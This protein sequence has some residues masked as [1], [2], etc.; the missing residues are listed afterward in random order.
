MFLVWLKFLI[1][2]ALVIF[3]GAKLSR[4]G[5]MIAGKTRL[6]GLWVGLLLLAAVTS[7]PELVT[8]IGAAA[9]VGSPDLA[10]GTAFGSNLFNLA[11]IAILDIVYRQGPLLTR[12]GTGHRLSAGV[13]IVLIGFAAGSI[14]LGREWGGALGWVG[15]YSPV[16]V[17]LYLLGVR[18]IFRF[19]QKRGGYQEARALRYKSIS[20]RRAYA[21]FAVAALAIIGLGTW[22]AIIGDELAVRTGWGS[23]FVGSLFLAATTSLP[24]LVVAIVALRLGAVDMA[25]ANMLGSNMFNMGIVIA[26]CDLFYRQAS[27]FSASSIS[28]VY[29]ASM[30]ILMTLIVIGGLTFRT[31]RKLPI[32]M[33]WYSVALIVAYLAGA[34]I[35]FTTGVPAG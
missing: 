30:A 2:A 33:S 4:Y 27:I 9:V 21:G 3:F 20:A 12:A 8:G 6:G 7:L 15:I 18:S 5:D 25:I 23:S 13:G 29:A 32:G 14:L 17:V 11:I 35:L 28:H 31:K 34:Y 10:L 26:G 19:E 1:C 24:E 22:L 16:L